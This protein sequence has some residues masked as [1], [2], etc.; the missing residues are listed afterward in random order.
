VTASYSVAVVGAGPTGLVL[1]NLLGKAGVRTLLIEAN[2]ATVAEPRAV[3]IDDE[4]LRVVQALGL[5]DEV[6]SE[7]V[8]GYGSEYLG[9]DRTMFLKVKPRA[10]P[11]GHPRRNAFRQPIF[12]AQLRQGLARFAAIETRF[13]CQA[14]SFEERGDGVIVDLRHADGTTDRIRADYLIGCDGSWS[15]TR[16]A[17]GYV[18]AGSSLDERWLILDLEQSPAASPETMVYCDPRRPG[19]M[20]PGPRDTRRYE[21]KLLAGETDEQILAD[22]RVADLLASHGAAPG[23]RIVRKTVYHFH[24]RLADHW[25]RDRVWLAGDAAHLMPPFAGQGMNSGVRDAANLA[26]KLAA[27]IA[28]RIGPGLLDSYER[29]RRGHVEEMIRL[30]LRMGA[31]F[32][33]RTTL[34]GWVIRSLFRLLGLWPAAKLYFAEMKYKPAPRFAGGFLLESQLSTR[35]IVGRLLPQPRLATRGDARLDDALGNGFALLG[36]GVDPQLVATL[37][38]GAGW[39]TLVERRLA[40][41][42]SDAESLSAYAGRLLLVRPDRYVMA[43]FAPAEADRIAAELTALLARSWP[44]SPGSMLAPETTRLAQPA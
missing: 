36:I 21:F 16:E 28:G 26:W 35:G 29:E 3:S 44:S 6:G 37:S 4:S 40:L 2:A 23:S 39:D 7:I 38:L 42:E 14:T 17:L 15:K 32:G 25:G 33:P 27:V 18:L 24:A 20:L 8:S 19:I 41:A 5:I 10:Q 34:H 1:A 12:E 11:Y 9:P 31:I 22:D 43:L 30:A 13:E